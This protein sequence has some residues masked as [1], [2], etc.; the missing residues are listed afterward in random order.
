LGSLAG[1]RLVATANHKLAFSA[2]ILRC[3]A[4]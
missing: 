4:K 3:T 1:D 2:L